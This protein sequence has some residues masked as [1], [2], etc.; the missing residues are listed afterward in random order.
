MTSTTILAIGIPL[1]IAIQTACEIYVWR[2]KMHYLKGASLLRKDQARRLR[3]QEKQ[4]IQQ[5]IVNATPK[6]S[7]WLGSV[8]LPEGE[9]KS[10]SSKLV[11]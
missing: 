10:F 2:R 3:Y 11:K 5:K 9:L 8:K 4:R 1:C 7:S 6:Y